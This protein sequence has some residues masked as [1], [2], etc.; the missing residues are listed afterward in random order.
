MSLLGAAPAPPPLDAAMDMAEGVSDVAVEIKNPPVAKD[1]SE[2][3]V[4]QAPAAEKKKKKKKKKSE[5]A[6]EQPPAAEK[7]KP[8]ALPLPDYAM[9]EITDPQPNDMLWDEGSGR[10]PDYHRYHAVVT[11]KK[12]QFDETVPLKERQ[13]T[14][15]EP[16]MKS[17]E[18][19]KDYQKKYPKRAL[20]HQIVQAAFAEYQGRFYVVRGGKRY[21]VDKTHRRVLVKGFG[22]LCSVKFSAEELVRQE[23]R[24]IKDYVQAVSRGED[25]P[26]ATD[27]K[28]GNT[29]VV[30]DKN[31]SDG[32]LRR[33]ENARDQG[34]L[35][36]AAALTASWSESKTRFLNVIWT[37][38]KKDTCEFIKFCK[39]KDILAI[40]SRFLEE[41]DLTADGITG[42]ANKDNRFFGV[43]ITDVIALGAELKKEPNQ[44]LNSLKDY[45]KP[46]KC[47]PNLWKRPGGSYNSKDVFIFHSPDMYSTKSGK[48]AMNNAKIPSTKVFL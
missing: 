20:G 47:N 21:E 23:E 26:I 10:G 9:G 31:K 44:A 8:D 40:F 42:E 12:A 32:Q 14:V 29:K 39:R 24:Q 19:F 6:V 15:P 35:T 4:E 34:I 7:K 36:S 17:K 2:V 37:L 43:I 5:L 25:P 11:A 33:Q 22:T 28:H 27:Q 41:G 1:V 18:T 45:M 48:Q 13:R 16:W 3:A 38:A 46:A 30:K